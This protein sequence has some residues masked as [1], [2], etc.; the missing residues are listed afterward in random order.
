MKML[1]SIFL[2]LINLMVF[3]LV[4]GVSQKRWC[5]K[6]ACGENVYCLK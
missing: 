4:L 6:T 1:L 2:V 5:N 3:L